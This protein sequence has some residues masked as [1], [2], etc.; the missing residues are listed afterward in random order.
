MFGIFERFWIK[1]VLILN[2]EIFVKLGYDV[3]LSVMINSYKILFLLFLF[4]F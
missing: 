3:L 4:C 2:I 1:L